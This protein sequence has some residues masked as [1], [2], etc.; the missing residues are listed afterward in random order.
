MHMLTMSPR[1]TIAPSEHQPRR[2]AILRQHQNQQTYTN[3]LD[4]GIQAIAETE[5][6]KQSQDTVRIDR[7]RSARTTKS[8]MAELFVGV[9]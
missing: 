8:A 1:T 5:H 4:I 7:G 6:P 2:R 3:H 9:G